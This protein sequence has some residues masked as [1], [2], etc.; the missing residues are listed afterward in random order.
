MD[1]S[2]CPE[3]SPPD[4]TPTHAPIAPVADV[5][6]AP[7]RDPSPPPPSAPEV[8]AY[9]APLPDPLPSSST[10]DKKYKQD[11]DVKEEEEEMVMKEESADADNASAP[12]DTTPAPPSTSNGVTEESESLSVILPHSH[13]EAPVES[14]IAQPEELCLPNG[15]PLPA[16][17]DP[18]APT[19][20]VAER[21]D[22]PIAEPDVG[23]EVETPPLMAISKTT[24]ILAVEGIPATVEQSAAAPVVQEAPS[25][26]VTHTQTNEPVVQEAVS[27]L[28]QEVTEDGP[29][30]QPIA[31]EEIPSPPETVSMVD[32]ATEK[33][34]TPPPLSAEET[35]DT[36]PALTVTPALVESTMQ[37]Q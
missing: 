28:T 3:D 21:D 12:S 6:D 22:S 31:K 10:Q 24:V 37:G 9:P 29:T 16:P 33:A 19:A 13:I 8:P 7:P 2:I 15:L 23:Q 34:P 5:M 18:E 4:A 27:P 14:P 32:D 26:P 1:A 20:N 25:A 17:E 30:A 11:T 36:T 35:E